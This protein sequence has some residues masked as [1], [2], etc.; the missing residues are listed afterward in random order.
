M[1]VSWRL[2]VVTLIIATMALGACAPGAPTAPPAATKAPAAPA[3]TAPAAA[4]T[5]AAAA[6]AKPAAAPTAA[7]AAEKPKRGGILK[8]AV[9]SEPTPNLDPHQNNNNPWGYE[10]VYGSYIQYVYNYSTKKWELKPFMV[11]SWSSPD[12]K[13]IVFKLKKGISFHDGSPWNAEAAKWNLDRHRGVDFKK[14]SYKAELEPINSIDVVDEYTIKI[15]LKTPSA[16]LVALLS[17]GSYRAHLMS[18]ESTKK[19]GD[20]WAER[21]M[22]GA[23]PMKFVEWKPDDRIILTKWDKYWE[24]G[25]D[26]QPLPYLDGVELIQARDMTT[27]VLNLRVGMFDGT[28]N[29]QPKDRLMLEKDPNFTIVDIGSGSANYYFFNMKDPLWGKN[30]KLR[31]AAQYAI[32][33]ES[34]AK[35]AGLGVGTAVYYH[36]SPD[37]LGYNESVPKYTFNAEKAKQL[38]KESG[39]QNVKIDLSTQATEINQRVAEIVKQMWD[40]VGLQTTISTYERTA[41]DNKW[42][43]GEFQVGASSKTWG[44]VDPDILSWRLTTGGNKNFAFTENKAL[45]DCMKEGRETVEATQRQKIYEKCQ[46]LVYEEAAYG[47]LYN[48]PN[49]AV[50]SKKLKGYTNEMPMNAPRITRA[51]LDK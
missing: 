1:R 48:T 8:L 28:D 40:Q 44:E 13:S 51:W 45:D 19:N 49:T 16:V 15:N 6:P 31:Q 32:D 20:A 50:F 14:T 12:P 38:I 22:V 34:L 7:P 9:G 11:E 33:N 47:I 3:A 21:N 25:D 39:A 10:A 46:T 17:D 42:R 24:K 29:I 36:W 2:L 37:M 35:A 4:P 27:K 41:M 30:Q 5:T 23:G 43:A 26:G 18:M